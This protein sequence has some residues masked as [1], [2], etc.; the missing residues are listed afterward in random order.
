VIPDE[1]LAR[2]VLGPA[3]CMF[4]P[5]ILRR[6]IGHRLKWFAGYVIECIIKIQEEESNGRV[7]QR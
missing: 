5:G 6:A 1:K 2:I 3:I 7:Q 4:L